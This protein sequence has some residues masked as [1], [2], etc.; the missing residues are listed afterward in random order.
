MSLGRAYRLYIDGKY[1]GTGLTRASAR[2]GA[3][4]MLVIYNR[5]NNRP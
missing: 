4:R 3:K 1:L 2:D 5:A